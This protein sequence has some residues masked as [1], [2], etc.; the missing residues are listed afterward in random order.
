LHPPARGRF[1]D[2]DRRL[3]FRRQLQTAAKPA[4][5]RFALG[6]G[7][8]VCQEHRAERRI[9]NERVVVETH[10][11][12]AD[13]RAIDDAGAPEWSRASHQLETCGYEADAILPREASKEGRHRGVPADRPEGGPQQQEQKDGEWH[14]GRGPALEERRKVDLAPA[15]DRY[16]DD[17]G[18][19]ADRYDLANRPA[20]EPEAEKCRVEVA[21]DSGRVQ[22]RRGVEDDRYWPLAAVHG[23]TTP[24]V[25]A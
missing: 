10:A 24:F 2:V 1:V 11:D 21:P 9:R 22:R 16:N 23:G 15:Q 12:P 4:A 6:A 7:P 13:V 19:Q 3:A 8:E 5:D 17:R 14:A 25:R 20:D 18:D